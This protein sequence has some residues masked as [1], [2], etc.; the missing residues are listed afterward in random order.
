[1]TLTAMKRRRNK[2]Q[3][4]RKLRKK[5]KRIHL[6]L[7]LRLKNQIRTPSLK[8]I[9]SKL[10]KHLVKMILDQKIFEQLKKLKKVKKST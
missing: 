9:L 10:K 5:R 6:N 4:P 8:T 1:M 7:L 2:L 3:Q